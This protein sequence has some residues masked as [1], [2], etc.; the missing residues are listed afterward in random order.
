MT[1]HRKDIK[2]KWLEALRSGEYKQGQSALVV[3]RLDR[4]DYPTFGAPPEKHYA[5]DSYC[6]LG[7]LCD[8]LHKQFQ[9]GTWVMEDNGAT[10]TFKYDHH[11]STGNLPVTI[12]EELGLSESTCSA[13]INMNDD[14]DKNFDE[15]AKYIEE[16][17]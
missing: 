5:P 14:D 3:T 9:M 10:H 12:Q 11:V 15:I 4:V 7:V 6:C 2:E 8:V 17:L 16:K 13:L 1:M